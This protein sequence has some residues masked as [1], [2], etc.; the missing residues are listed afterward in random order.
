MSRELMNLGL[1]TGFCFQTGSRLFLACGYMP[2]AAYR[3][4][5][6]RLPL[7]AFEHIP[8][9]QDTRCSGVDVLLI[10]LIFSRSMS[11]SSFNMNNLQIFFDKAFSFPVVLFGNH[12]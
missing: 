7:S 12:I 6:M 9:C 1:G 2:S 4:S 8:A 3:S 11:H 5:K 10:L